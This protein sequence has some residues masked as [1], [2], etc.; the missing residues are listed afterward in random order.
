[1]MGLRSFDLI[2]PQ[3]ATVARESSSVL[4]LVSMAALGLSVNMRTDFASGGRGLLS[5]LALA[6]MSAIGLMIL[7]AN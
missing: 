2:P 1:M 7:H 6:F 5:M 3:A 4:T